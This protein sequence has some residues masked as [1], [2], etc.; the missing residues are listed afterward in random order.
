MM[1]A[2]KTPVVLAI[3]GG[4]ACGKSEVGR[5]LKTM[6]FAVCDSDLVAHDLMKRELRSINK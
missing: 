5:I 3:T 1:C 4:I 2:L 6:G